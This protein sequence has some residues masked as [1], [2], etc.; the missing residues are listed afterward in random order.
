MSGNGFQIRIIEFF[1]NPEHAHSNNS[2]FALG[3]LCSGV[4]SESELLYARNMTGNR[5]EVYPVKRNVLVI[6]MS[7]A[8]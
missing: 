1:T 2:E 4:R 5:Q 3:F 7:A 6:L 8:M